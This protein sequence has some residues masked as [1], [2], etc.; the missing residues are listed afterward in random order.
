MEYNIVVKINKLFL[1]AI[2]CRRPNAEQKEPHP[3]EYTL[4]KST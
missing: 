4:P 3:E 1:Q 2:T